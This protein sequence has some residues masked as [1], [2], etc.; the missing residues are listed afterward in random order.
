L[1]RRL[2][3]HKQGLID[4]FTKKYQCKYL[5]YYE[6][7]SDVNNAISREKQLKRWTR[8]K[9]ENLINKLNPGWK[10]LSAEWR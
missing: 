2:S 6:D 5:I 1:E 10:D 4:G 9:K 3:E 7:Y 8:V